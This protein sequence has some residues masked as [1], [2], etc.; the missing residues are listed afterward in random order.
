M[1]DSLAVHNPAL[2]LWL[3][4]TSSRRQVIAD[5]QVISHKAYGK[6]AVGADSAR[7]VITFIV[8]LGTRNT[9]R[10]DPSGTFPQ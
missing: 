1:D 5:G 4:G 2:A 7:L 9:A 10:S 8:R 6:P 3:G